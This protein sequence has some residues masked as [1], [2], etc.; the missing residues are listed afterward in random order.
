M[1][2]SFTLLHNSN[3]LKFLIASNNLPDD[4]MFCTL[5]PLFSISLLI[6]LYTTIT[7]GYT[8][9]TQIRRQNTTLLCLVRT[10]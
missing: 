8:E 9:G 1:L 7:Q 5:L 2:V 6:N 10:V 4:I 3:L